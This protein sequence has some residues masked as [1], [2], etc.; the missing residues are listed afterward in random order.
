MKRHEALLLKDLQRA[1]KGGTPVRTQEHPAMVLEKT[2]PPEIPEM[3][4]EPM[5]PS[6]YTGQDAIRYLTKL[7]L[8]QRRGR[9]DK[10]SA[11]AEKEKM[12]ENTQRTEKQATVKHTDDSRVSELQLNKSSG[13]EVPVG[14]TVDASG[15]SVS[16]SKSAKN[17][18]ITEPPGVDPHLHHPPD[19]HSDSRG[20]SDPSNG[21]GVSANATENNQSAQ[22]VEANP[23]TESTGQEEEQGESPVQSDPWNA[24]G[25]KTPGTSQQP[26]TE[27]S[28]HNRFVEATLLGDDDVRDYSDKKD[29][30]PSALQNKGTVTVQ[31]P[32]EGGAQEKDE[33]DRLE[34]SDSS[35]EPDLEM[36][37]RE[38][39]SSRETKQELETGK[40]T[41]EG[42]TEPDSRQ[43]AQ[44][45]QNQNQS[46]GKLPTISLQGRSQ[47][48]DMSSVKVGADDDDYGIDPELEELIAE[49]AKT[50]NEQKTPVPR[51]VPAK[52][53]SRNDI[54]EEETRKRFPGIR[55]WPT[56]EECMQSPLPKYIV[57]TSTWL[58]VTA[59]GVK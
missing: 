56:L 59:K 5:L 57:F 28:S 34:S 49:T 6:I 8:I 41:Q 19:T 22:A 31:T 54:R 3:K 25:A 42:N 15:G 58:S 40:S 29:V 46:K 37:N 55:P 50:I 7:A 33:R 26:L 17:S 43:R 11:E 13:S 48:L 35:R 4:V 53:K 14:E 51:R 21:G 45:Q 20:E 32:S 44:L 9:K 38:P 24:T 1:M 23:K 27:P 52:I 2:D 16:S 39:K 47:T 36:N 10:E 30:S 18:V 12:R